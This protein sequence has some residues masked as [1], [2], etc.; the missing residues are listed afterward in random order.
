MQTCPRTEQACPP[1]CQSPAHRG[2]VLRA[3]KPRTSRSRHILPGVQG[4]PH[5]CGTRSAPV[6][7]PPPL[8]Q[9]VQPGAVLLQQSGGHLQSVPGLYGFA[10]INVGAKDNACCHGL[11]L[12]A[13]RKTRG[14]RHS[15]VGYPLPGP[16]WICTSHHLLVGTRF[17]IL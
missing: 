12:E 8:L 16:T 13:A 2:T 17:P 10:C 11:P 9:P 1:L 5:F 7:L 15:S 6:S 3:R 14:G 4:A